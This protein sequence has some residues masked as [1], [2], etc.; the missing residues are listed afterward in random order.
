VDTGSLPIFAFT[1]L[2]FVGSIVMTNSGIDKLLTTS[3]LPN[4][5]SL[6]SANYIYYSAAV[7]SGRP[8]SLIIPSELLAHLDAFQVRPAKTDGFSASAFK[9]SRILV[10]PSRRGWNLRQFA[11]IAPSVRYI[12]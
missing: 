11:A 9:H 6:R 8:D 10:E 5:R 1:R 3:A 12:R 7:R 4:L 2:A